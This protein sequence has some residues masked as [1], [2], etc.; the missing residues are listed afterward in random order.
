MTVILTGVRWYL[1]AVLF[2]NLIISNEHFFMCL[3]SIVMSSLKKCLF[4]YPVRFFFS[5]KFFSHL[6]YYRG[7]GKVACAIQTAGSLLVINSKHSS[8]YLSVSNSQVS[9]LPLL[10]QPMA[11]TS[12]FSKSVS[13]LL[14]CWHIHLYNYFNHFKVYNSVALNMF[15]TLSH[16]HQY[17]IPKCF[18]NP[19]ANLV[20]T[21]P[22]SLAP[23]H[24]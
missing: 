5:K 24:H 1:I 16:H 2:C 10:W 19:N 22:L 11:T 23:G 3:L 21:L 6:G 4:R 9:L 15:T 13:P 20:P 18:I 8:A 17:L 12:L 14:C 7:F